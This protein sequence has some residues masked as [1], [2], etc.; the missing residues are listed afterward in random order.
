MCSFVGTRGKVEAV[1]VMKTLASAR[2]GR[3]VEHEIRVEKDVRET[4][5]GYGLRLIR[6]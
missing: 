2:H 4:L 3:V 1:G 6:E 5:R